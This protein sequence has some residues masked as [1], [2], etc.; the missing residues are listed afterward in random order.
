M[1]VRSLSRQIANSLIGK[2]VLA[3]VI[4]EDCLKDTVYK[5]AYFYCK[6]NDPAK[7]G[8]MNIFKELIS[9]LLKQ[10]EELIPYCYDKQMG[11]GDVTLSSMVLVDGLLKVFIDALPKV[12]IIIDGVDECKAVERKIVLNKL[13]DLVADCDRGVPGKLRV[14]VVSQFSKD[15]EKL[16]PGASIMS[17]SSVDN[18]DDIKKYVQIYSE[19]IQKRQGLSPEEL[20]DLRNKVWLRSDG[21]Y[22]ATCRGSSRC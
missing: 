6:E 12:F 10:R 17:L 5:T 19:K 11:A 13:S 9:Q 7:H 1:E 20:E 18:Q 14:L 16:L 21:M 2:T 3:S 4:I 22:L 8:S 15:I